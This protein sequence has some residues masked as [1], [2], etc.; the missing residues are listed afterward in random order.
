MLLDL[1]A[2]FLGQQINHSKLVFSLGHHNW[3]GT[4]FWGPKD[5]NRDASF[6]SSGAAIDEG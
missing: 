4:M 2:D 5:A 3:R 1:F 6:V